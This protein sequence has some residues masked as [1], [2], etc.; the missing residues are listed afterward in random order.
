MT[1]RPLWWAILL[2]SVCTVG[3]LVVFWSWISNPEHLKALILQQVQAAIG[4]EIEAGEAALA[5]FPRPRLTLAEV[6]I[7]DVDSS[8]VFLTARRFEIV[9]RSTPLLRMQVVIK[10]IAIE[11]P[12]MMVHCDGNGQ[13]NVLTPG[14]SSTKIGRVVGDPLGFLMVLEETTLSE[15]IV[16]VVDACRADGTRKI[17]LTNLNIT[18]KAQRQGPPLD[19]RLTGRIPAGSHATSVLVTGTLSHVLGTGAA[20]PRDQLPFQFQGMLELSQVD[21]HLLMDWFSPRPVPE[22][23]AG[24]AYLASRFSVVPGVTGFDLMFSDMTASIEPLL[25]RG[26]ASLSGLMTKQPTFALTVSVSPVTLRELL[27]RVPPQWLP[28]E[29]RSLLTEREISGTVEVVTASITGSTTPTLHASVTG[30][31]RIREGQVLLGRNKVRA[32]NLAGTVWLHPNRIRVTDLTGQYGPLRITTGR[33]TVAFL[34]QGPLLDLEVGGDMEARDLVRLLRDAIDSE[35]VSKALAQWRWIHGQTNVL[36]QLS[37]RLDQPDSLRLTRAEIVPQHVSVVLPVFPEPVTKLAGRLVYAQGAL[38]FDEV[39]GGLGQAQFKLNGAVT[40][41][42]AARF[43]GLTA[44][45]WMPASQLLTWLSSSSTAST[46][47]QGAVSLGLSVTGPVLAPQ[48]KGA[49]DLSGAGVAVAGLLKKPVGQ[50]A[51]VDFSATVLRNGTLSVPRFDL[52]MP[53]V[54]LSGRAMIQ[55][56]PVWRVSGSLLSGPIP[57]SELPPGMIVGGLESGTLEVSLDVRGKGQDWR[58][59]SCTGWIAL[60]DGRF[61][62]PAIEHPLTDIYLRLNL[63]RAQADVK[64]LEFRIGDSFVRL[65]GT[66]TNWRTTPVITVTIESP[67]LDFELLIPKGERS[68]IRDALE[69]LA[70]SSRVLATVHVTRGRYKQL[71]VREVSA[72][73]AIGDETLVINDMDGYIEDGHVTDSRLVLSLPRRKPAQGELT[74]RV[75]SLPAET[76]LKLVDDR[77]RLMTGEVFLGATLQAH[78]RHPGGVAHTLNG[79]VEFT[80][81]NGRI[82]KGNIVPKILMM[83]DIPSRLQGKLDLGQDGLPFDSIRGQVIVE[84][85]IV[86]TKNLLIDSPVVKISAAGTYVIPA[87]ELDLAIVVS[88]FGSY[89]RL[90][91]SIPLFGKLIAG[92]R[93]GFTTA[94]FDVKGSLRAP[95]IINRPLKSIGAGLTGLAQLA[96][97]VLRNALMLPAELFPPGDETGGPPDS[98]LATSP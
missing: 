62:S 56:K 70:A 58:T 13:W 8:Q 82:I 22:G 72:R 19:I 65:V 60:T 68:P 77:Q 7:R 28:S 49:V 95:Q 73:L 80:I 37:G 20:T 92:E 67:N 21:L 15:G 3:L 94:F 30:E 64:R 86:T 87:D 17:D 29:V 74:L 6:V 61:V 63:L 57:L 54:R 12:R 55:R 85:G 5:L 44:W 40:V 84:N 76:L 51:V 11:Q 27:A 89:T 81:R 93:Q 24:Q 25:I 98:Q 43:E 26:Q 1:S 78:G 18:M 41:G 42:Q 83:L 45:V 71:I 75:T 38:A 4:R 69:A 96:F 33:L 10:R 31:L 32:T 48:L 9:L 53:P 59:W 66:I 88:P 52:L 50:P 39:T 16:S 34:E 36:F 97:D 23:V 46:G 47:V 90:L 2:A 91:Q 14:S 35:S 79:S